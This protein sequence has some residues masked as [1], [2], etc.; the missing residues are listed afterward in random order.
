MKNVYVSE[1]NIDFMIR[2]LRNC[3]CGEAPIG[4]SIYTINDL[5]VSVSSSSSSACTIN[6]VGR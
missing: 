1:Y 3:V 6:E 2:K 5:N 4:L